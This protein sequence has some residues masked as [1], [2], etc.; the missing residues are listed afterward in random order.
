MSNASERNPRDPEIGSTSRG[1][2]K[3]AVLEVSALA[4]KG[5]GDPITVKGEVH[6]RQTPAHDP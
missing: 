4:G 2:G 6:G 1:D 3:R 5:A